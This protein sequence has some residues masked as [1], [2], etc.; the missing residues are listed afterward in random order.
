[1][2]RRFG[3]RHAAALWRS[4]Y[5]G[6]QEPHPQGRPGE[7]PCGVW[8]SAQAL[9]CLFELRGGG[10]AKRACKQ[11]QRLRVL[12]YGTARAPHRRGSAAPSVVARSRKA[13]SGRMIGAALATL[14]ADATTQDELYLACSS[15]SS[16]PY[17][18]NEMSDALS[19]LGDFLRGADAAVSRAAICVERLR[20]VLGM[21]TWAVVQAHPLYAVVADFVRWERECV[22]ALRGR[23]LLGPLPAGVW[24]LRWTIRGLCCELVSGVC[25]ARAVLMRWRSCSARSLLNSGVLSVTVTLNL[26]LNSYAALYGVCVAPHAV[27]HHREV[28]QSK[29]FFHRD[30][31][32]KPDQYDTVL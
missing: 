1:M 26:R 22:C 17:S 18:S 20:C 11:A 27:P 29:N 13:T 14:L 3:T 24:L 9:P 4:L 23:D 10:S 5:G 32:T 6:R 19:A 8:L 7:V 31:N 12:Q 21:G 30:Q 16:S 2:R 28:H 15:S 25:L